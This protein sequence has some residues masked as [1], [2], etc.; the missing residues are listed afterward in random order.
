MCLGSPAI[1]AVGAVR[2]GLYA[3]HKVLRVV[4][5]E[6]KKLQNVTAKQ[7]RCIRYVYYDELMVLILAIGICKCM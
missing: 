4:Y 3:L 6:F 5:N 7:K 2:V 1:T